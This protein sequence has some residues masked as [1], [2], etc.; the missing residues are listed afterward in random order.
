MRRKLLASRFVR[1]LDAGP[2]VEFAIIVPILLL[3]LVGIFELAWAFNRRNSFVT[4][5]REGARFAS[6]SPDYPCSGTVPDSVKH[7]MAR[8]FVAGRDT[9]PWANIVVSCPDSTT[10]QVQVVNM[11]YQSM[12]GVS[13]PRFLGRGI[14]LSASATF[15][16]ERAW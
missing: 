3:L 6:V 7:A 9:V 13:L 12:L 16:W 11:P 8:R 2:I 15:R 10:V 5:A 4:A 14:T 1:E